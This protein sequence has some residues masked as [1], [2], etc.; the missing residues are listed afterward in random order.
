MA[1]QESLVKQHAAF[2][3]QDREA[4]D[5]G[6]LLNERAGCERV[7][8]VASGNKSSGAGGKLDGADEGLSGRDVGRA[9]NCI[10]RIDESRGGSG[11]LASYST[12]ATGNR[13]DEH[14]PLGTCGCTVQGDGLGGSCD[15]RSIVLVK[16]ESRYVNRVVRG[17]GGDGSLSDN[18]LQASGHTLRAVP[19]RSRR[20]AVEA[21]RVGDALNGL[22][23]VLGESLIAQADTVASR[24]PQLA[25]LTSNT[26]H[27][28]FLLL[29]VSLEC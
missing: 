26:S 27:N 11:N 9:C 1:P 16:R 22:R 28:E 25:S 15:Q 20:R 14:M 17:A 21:V 23:G 13:R 29:N 18:T 19:C 4:G 12:N 5:V 3:G 24:N 2:H 8:D 7:G 6:A 10:P